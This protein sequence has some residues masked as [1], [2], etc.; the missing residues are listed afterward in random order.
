[1]SDV[2]EIKLQVKDESEL[3]NP[4][5]GEGRMFSDDVVDFIYY[6]YQKNKPGSRF[7]IYVVSDKPVDE[8]KFKN[9]FNA[10]LDSMR[11]QLKIDKNKNAVKQAWLLGIG[12]ILISLYIYTSNFI[13]EL[14]SE[15]LSIIGAFSIW[16]TANI[17][18]V[19]IP[20]TNFKRKRVEN[21]SRTEIV[22]DTL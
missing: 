16:E 13:A 17:W 12:I 5:D 20:E 19:K 8:Q 11:L 1:M 7:R 2:Y 4:L 15:I 6:R 9:A 14:P 3:Y 22:F 18:I 10:L 21:L